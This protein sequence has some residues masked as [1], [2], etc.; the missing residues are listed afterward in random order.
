MPPTLADDAFNRV[1]FA[2]LDTL[3]DRDLYALS[4]TLAG[5]ADSGREER[6]RARFSDIPSTARRGAMRPL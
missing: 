3:T 1:E 5:A 6:W 4:A 2:D